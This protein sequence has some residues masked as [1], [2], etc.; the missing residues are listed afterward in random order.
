MAQ[1]LSRVCFLAATVE[2][3]AICNPVPGYLMP[4]FEFCG[5]LHAYGILKYMHTYIQ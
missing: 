4:C 3:T 5:L 1:K 2:L